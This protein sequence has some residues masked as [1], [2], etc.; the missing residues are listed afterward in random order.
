MSHRFILWFPTLHGH[1][2]RKERAG[3]RGFR[4]AAVPPS[5]FQGAS[6]SG[7]ASSAIPWIRRK[8][9]LL[10]PPARLKVLAPQRD[11]SLN[12]RRR[13]RHTRHFFLV[14]VFM[15][16]LTLQALLTSLRDRLGE[17]YL[18]GENANR[19]S[20]WAVPAMC[21]AFRRTKG[22]CGAGFT[23]TLCNQVLHSLFSSTLFS[24]LD[25]ILASRTSINCTSSRRSILR[26]PSCQRLPKF[27]LPPHD[28]PH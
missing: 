3:R 12:R 23:S 25:D 1:R 8:E 20:R 14:Q 5:R 15:L 2:R 26:P 22:P 7:S 21:S 18:F 27:S 10:A 9:V 16:S 17:F 11:I 6:Y 4:P 28:S 13:R 19:A 24:T